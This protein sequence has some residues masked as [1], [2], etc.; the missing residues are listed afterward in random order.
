MTANFYLPAKPAGR[1]PAILIVH[2]QHYP[3][4][5]GELHDMGELWARA[6][7]AV[8][9]I[10]RAGY[11]ERVETVPWYR[12]GYGS[13]YNFSTQLFVVGESYSGWTAWDVIRSVD[14]L[15]ER[16]E[17][18]KDKIVLLG[19]VAGGGEIVGVAAALDPRITAVAPFNYDQGH[20][21][22]HGDSP[23]QIAGQF[24]PWLVAASVA[25]RK[26][27]RAFEFGW[28]GAEEPDYPSLW[29]DGMARS[30]KVWGLYA[31]DNLASAQGYGLIR[32]S[33]ERVSHCFSIGPQQ[34]AGLYPHLQRW[35]QIPYPSAEDLRILPDSELSTNPVREEARQQEAAR[36]RPLSEL[37]SIT[38]ATAEEIKRRAMHEIAYDLG[39]EQ[40]RAARTGRGVTLARLRKELKPMLGDIEPNGNA[41]AQ[42]F[43]RRSIGGVQ[44]EAL[45]ITVEDGIAVPMLVIS[46]GKRK[47]PA[48]VAI[49]QEGKERFLE[50]RAKEIASLLRSGIAVCLPEVRGTGET[51]P[52][53]RADGGAFHRI[54]QMEF[55]LGRSLLGRGSRTCGP[56]WHTCGGAKTSTGA[57]WP[58]GVIRSHHPIRRTC[59]WTRWNSKEGR[60]SNAGPSPWERTWRC[61]RPCTKTAYRQ[62][63]LEAGWQGI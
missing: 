49:A 48:V 2:S 43:G 59:G 10:E 62:W 55:D 32:L 6:G 27:I 23:G 42:S 28:E 31:S 19:S 16:P 12:Q 29:F 45:S 61:W 5:Q 34:R 26:F 50:N 4:T 9:L 35:F 47:A 17:V 53:T 30:Q 44:A 11:G 22:V 18:D 24:S 63:W 13:R 52:G 38:P 3:K 58:C 21:R 46:P 36:R 1:V 14:F 40:L 60:R 20:V 7:C 51:A 56:C 57:S 37:V 15:Y 41:Q 25:P 54:A 8:L 39:Q 33:M